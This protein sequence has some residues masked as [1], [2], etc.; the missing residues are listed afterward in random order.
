MK[1]TNNDTMSFCKQNT[2]LLF[3]LFEIMRKIKQFYPATFHKITT[4]D[5]V[6]FD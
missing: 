2:S 4:E 6:S 5:F 3:L 1:K